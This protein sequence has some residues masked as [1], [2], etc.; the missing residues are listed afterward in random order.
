MLFI[1]RYVLG[2]AL[3]RANTSGS[4]TAVPNSVTP[5]KNQCRIQ[6]EDTLRR[7]EIGG[8]RMIIST[9]PVCL[10]ALTVMRRKFRTKPARTADTIAVVKP[11]W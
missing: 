3:S 10:S 9:A 6:R 5:G 2:R 1:R 8:G 7:G 4:L 11:S